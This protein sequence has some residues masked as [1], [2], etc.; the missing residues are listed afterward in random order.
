[1]QKPTIDKKR[2][3]PKSHVKLPNGY[4]SIVTLSG[5]RRRPF[6]ARP[7]VKDWDEKGHP[8]YGKPIGYF[9][10][11]LE[12]FEALAEWNKNPFDTASRNLT[13]EEVY[14]RFYHA[15]YEDP[16]VQYSSSSKTCTKSAFKN[17][18]A[19]HKMIFYDLTSL[20]LQR[21]LDD[22]PLK[23]AS[24]EH[25]M[26]LFKQ[27]Y[28]FAIQYDMAPKDWSE[29]VK[30]K[31]PD[32]DEAGVPFTREEL[33]ILWANKEVAWV[34]T[35][36]IL[37]YSGFRLEGM[38]SVK[39]NLEKMYFR[40]GVKNKASKNRIVPIHSRIQEIVVDRI[41][42]YGTILN[43][44]TAQ[45]RVHFYETLSTL[46][47]VKHTPHD[48]RATFATMGSAAG[49]PD[50]YLKRLLGHSLGKDITQSKYIKPELSDLRE[51]IELIP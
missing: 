18:T 19:L 30:I 2:T 11:W 22:C 36:L 13:F 12:A 39:V 14:E 48:C 34:D 44:G 29:F 15:K 51:A 9:E 8:I 38:A 17:S 35:I 50:P 46:N 47:I 45:Y 7:P 41:Q 24:L 40:G 21:V 3:K 20:D 27:M 49:V 1:M 6:M 16:I 10:T 37:C 32:D 4:G 31:K 42:K 26:N 43:I 5:N 25:I 28:G 33:E 23:H